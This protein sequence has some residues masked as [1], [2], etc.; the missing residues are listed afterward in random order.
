MV[1]VEHSAPHIHVG[2]LLRGGF[3]VDGGLFG[4][5]IVDVGAGAFFGFANAHRLAGDDLGDFSVRIVHIASDDSAFRADDDA[6]GLQ[7]DLDAMSAI[8]ALG[9]G[10]A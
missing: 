3:W 4:A 5:E 1:G 10:V 9:G 2:K 6:G 7:A 8:V